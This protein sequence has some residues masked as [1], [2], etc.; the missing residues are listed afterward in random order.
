LRALALATLARGLAQARR[1]DEA[2]AA[3]AEA[4]EVLRAQG[5]LEDGETA[6]RLA[7]VEALQAA[8][9]G[10]AAAEAA[11]EAALRLRVRADRITDRAWRESFLTRVPD[12]AAT[13][14]VAADLG[15]TLR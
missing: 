10:E 11:R 6:V 4:M 13:L 8:G 12:N 5:E 2:R 1:A 15:G 9:D 3:A 14:A 7:W